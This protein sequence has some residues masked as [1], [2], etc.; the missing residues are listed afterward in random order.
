VAGKK[1]HAT[2]RGLVQDQ[3]FCLIV[4]ATEEARGGDDNLGAM[5]EY[6]LERLGGIPCLRHDLHVRLIFEQSAKALAQQDVVVH[7]DAPNPVT[8]EQTFTLD[9]CGG[10]HSSSLLSQ[11]I[12]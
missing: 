5:L 7:Q 4:G 10:T 1:Q 3:P 8:A 11:R 9:L 12:F 2:L 6:S